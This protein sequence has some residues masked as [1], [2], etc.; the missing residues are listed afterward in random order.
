[1]FL[2]A[3][4]AALV[5]IAPAAAGESR[6]TKIDL[7]GCPEGQV[8]EED[9]AAFEVICPGVEGWEVRVVEGDLRFHVEPRPE[10]AD[11]KLI[12]ETLPAFNNIHD[13]LEWRGEDGNGGFVP[14]AVILRYFTDDG[15]GDE[16]T[17]GNILVVTKVTRTRACHAA[18]VDAKAIGEGA[19]ETAQ[20]AADTVARGFECGTHTPVW[21]YPRQVFTD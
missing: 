5:F 4:L 1:M 15:L 18:Y 17:K 7:Q 13:M 10:G 6:Y 8:F 19:N 2:A 21:V 20:L 16:G 9:A 11:T 14:Y 3:A 12:F